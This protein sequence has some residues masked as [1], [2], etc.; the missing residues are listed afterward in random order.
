MLA[1]ALGFLAAHGPRVLVLGVIVGLAVPPLAAVLRPALAVSVMVML[2]GMLLRVDWGEFFAHLKRP[3]LV[4]V[5]WPWLVVA[6]PV[7]VWAATAPLPISPGL[8][9]AVVLMSCSAPLAASPAFVLLIGL[10]VSLALVTMLLSVFTI[11][12]TMPLLALGLLGLDL[13]LGIAEFMARL[14]GLIGGAFALMLVLRLVVPARALRAHART[15]DGGLVLFLALFGVALM[16]GVTA[17]FLARPAFVLGLAL[18]SFVANFSLQGLG[19]LAF[20]RAGARRALTLGFLTG[21]RNMAV[22]L[23]SLPAGT[24]PT[25]LFYFA[26]AQLPMYAAP[27]ILVPIYRRLARGRV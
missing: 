9:A 27:A 26:V 3:G 22:L 5:A 4:I 10:D 8:R 20:A 2:A 1:R 23:A 21:N 11:P 13:N 7:T 17:L 25:I 16:D 15:I 12:F 18:A 6:I 14:G 24:D 19:A